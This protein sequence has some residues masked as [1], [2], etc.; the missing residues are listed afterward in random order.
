MGHGWWRY[1]ACIADLDDGLNIEIVA[2]GALQ[3]NM[4]QEKRFKIRDQSLDSSDGSVQCANKRQHNAS[5]KGAAL[6][7]D[8]DGLAQD[9]LTAIY[10]AVR[11]H[12]A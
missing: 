2:G 12:G 7:Q 8:V 9:S 5:E 3:P 4:R 1:S 10:N 6:P 11:L